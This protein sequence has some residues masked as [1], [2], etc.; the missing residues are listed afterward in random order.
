MAIPGY[1]PVSSSDPL[2]FGDNMLTRSDDGSSTAINIAAIFEDGIVIGGQTFTSLYLNNNGNISFGIPLSTF[3][4]GVI[5]G[6]TGLNIIAPYWADVDTSVDVP[7]V[8]DGVFWDFKPG[9]DSIAFTWNQVGYFNGH[10]DLL[11]TFQLELIDRGAGAVEIIFRYSAV[12]WTTGDSSGG[13]GGLGG[14]VARAGFTLGGTY[15]ELPSSGSQAAMLN[16]DSQDGNL[17]VTGVWQFFLQDGT[18]SGFGTTA[19][20][21]FVGTT[22]RDIWFGL[23]G[24]DTAQG[25]GTGDVLYGNAGN[26]SLLGQSGNDRLYGDFG[27]DRLF[28]G[29]GDDLLNGGAGNDL[30]AGGDG[31]DRAEFL[32]SAA[33]DMEVNLRLGTAIGMGTDT[34]GSIEHVTTGAGADRVI[35]SA[36]NNRISTNGGADRLIGNGGADRLD[37]GTGN[38]HLF[39]GTGADRFLFSRGDGSDTLR[40]FQDGIDRFEIASGAASFAD[41]SVADVGAD[42]R[43]SFANVVILVRNMAHTAIDASDFVFA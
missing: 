5:G 42:V 3:T 25:M 8:N 16:L 27:A 22:R 37:G 23:A 24:N 2:A 20:D 13:T 36:G 7:G 26:D 39:G 34:L 1:T 40:D 11:N 14:N 38:D 41:I 31:L 19:A 18:P 15:F 29:I 21:S 4:P 43:V 33:Q 28:G 17:G 32:S 35:G 30:L 6:N 10:T 12:S 9:R